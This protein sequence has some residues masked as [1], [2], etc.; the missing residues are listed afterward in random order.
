MMMLTMSESVKCVCVLVTLLGVVVG[1]TQGRAAR[2]EGAP[3]HCSWQRLTPEGTLGLACHLRTVAGAPALLADLPAPQ[4]ERVSSLSLECTDVLFFESSLEIGKRADDA[5]FLGHLKKLKELHIEF[6][7]IRYIP[8]SVLAPLRD[9]RTLSL[10]THNTDWSAMSMEFHRDSFRGLTELRT[11]DLGDNNIWTLPAEVFCPLFNLKELNLTSNRLQDISQM[12]FSDWGEGPTAPGKSCNGALE[13]LDVSQNDIITLPDNGLSSLRSLRNLFLQEN[14]ISVVA[15]RAFVGLSALQVM[16]LSSNSLLALPPEM[17]Q[18][19]RDIKQIYLNNNSISVLA[20][21]LLEGLDQLQILDLSVNDLTSEWVNRDTFSGLVRLIVLNLSHNKISKI[22]SLL[23]QD[24]NN[25]QFL[26]LENNKILKISE[27]AFSNLKNIHSLSMAHNRLTHVDSYHF[28]NLYVL[29]QLFLDGNRIESVHARSFENITKLQDLGLSGNLLKEIPEAI[30]SLRFLK[31]LDLGNND[32]SVVESSLFEGLDDLYG[33][34]L[35]DNKIVN[36]TKDAF[37]SLPS[38]QILNLASNKINHVDQSAFGSN[39]TIRAIR[40]DGNEL[41][42]VRGVFTN[43]NGL[44]WLNISDN[45]LM[46]FDYS[47]L[48]A[49]LEW[50]DMHR[51]QIQ[52][53]ENYFDLKTNVNIKMLD[54]SYNL[55]T[56]V[57]ESSIPNSIEV[58][59]LNDNQINRVNSGTFLHKPNL[60]KVVLYGNKIKTVDIGAFALSPVSEEKDLP[61]FYIGGNPFHCDCT[62]EWLQRINH[63]SHLRQHPRVMDLDIVTCTLAHSRGKISDFLL[64]VKPSQFLCP[65]ETHCFALCHCCEF[66][67]CDCEMTCP[68]RCTCYHDLTWSSNVVD[69]SNAGFE[70]VPERIPMDATEIYLDGNNLGELGNHVFIGKKK[71]QT[72]YLNNSNINSIHNRS[73]NGIDSLRILHLENNNIEKLD[74]MEFRKLSNLNVL[75]LE[76]NKI[77]TIHNES[78]SAMSSLEIL[79]LDNNGVVDFLPWKILNDASLQTKLSLQG[80]KWQCSC[81]EIIKLEQWLL[82]HSQDPDSTPCHAIEGDSNTANSTNSTVAGFLLKCRKLVEQSTVGSVT[83]KHLFL[84]SSKLTENYIPYVAIVLIVTIVILLVCALLFMFREE[85]RL[86]VHSKYGVRVFTCSA[87][88]LNDFKD[89]G[90]DA[91]VVYSIRDEDFVARAIATELEQSGHSLC[92]HHRDLQAGERCSDDGIVRGVENSKRLIIVLSISFLQNEW[93]KAEFKSALQS[94]INSTNASH[95]RQKIIFIVTTDLSALD[96]DPDLK[97]LLKTCTVIVWGEKNCREKLNFRLPDVKIKSPN[98]THSVN[99][100][101]IVNEGGKN[102]NMRYTASPTCHD[103]WFKY[104]GG[105]GSPGVGTPSPPQSTYVSGVGS[106]D[107]A[108]SEGLEHSYASI[109]S[110][111]QL[112]LRQPCRP[113]APCVPC[114]PP[115]HPPHPPHLPMHH[116]ASRKT[117]FV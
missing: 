88:E 89:R 44:G 30:K 8:A 12:G 95:R 77:R 112:P 41:T 86:W 27:G 113:C 60:E 107:E 6:C 57:D 71:L 93:Y 42:D 31:S 29:N 52:K 38:L 48:P 37:I 16:N 67:A 2:L 83:Q 19:S 104:Y 55:L 101:K 22:D 49:S 72:L 64:D 84:D 18:S 96:L 50:L 79:K 13:T 45:N 7:K 85:F 111:E 80:N 33:M 98:R 106:E 17:F 102:V 65:Y 59:F 39:P 63:L 99:N 97:V 9:L 91:Y 47:H 109:D 4:A 40:L 53:L 110:R 1:G 3:R 21:G 23:F 43:M 62:M 14:S 81:V 35:V 105:A 46:W 15:D 69:C 90:Y 87:K 51:N 73:F 76:H 58:L 20:P 34:R 116:A 82:S 61:E 68:D 28:S 56:S 36:I 74:G 100:A 25:L 115:P 11:L 75:H 10:R 114:A 32:I 78:F 54:V 26:S 103:T 92:L 24:L 94:G 70:K 108:G 117:Y 5:S 66:D